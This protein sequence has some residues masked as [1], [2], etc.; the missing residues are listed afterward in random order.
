MRFSKSL[1]QIT[2]L[3]CL[4]G[5]ANQNFKAEE[6]VDYRDNAKYGFGSLIKDKDSV[7]R[8][9]FTSNKTSE[10]QGNNISVESVSLSNS[11]NKLWNAVIIA[12]KDFPICFMDKKNGTLETEKVKVPQFDNTGSCSYII[13][14]KLLNQKDF[15][16]IVS[17]NEDSNVRL[18]KH[19]EII[20]E[21]IKTELNK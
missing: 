8:K 21:K 3:A 7:L 12:L 20:R 18:R 4:S 19:E 16:V 17:S 10:T 1:I 13:K 9:Y 14:V 11:E 15:T 6:P 2:L 5:C